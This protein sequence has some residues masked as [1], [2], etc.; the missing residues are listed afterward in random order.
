MWTLVPV[1]ETHFTPPFNQ[2]HGGILVRK[3]GLCIYFIDR[4]REN[5]LL[6]QCM[7]N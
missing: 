3:Q 1:V 6:R 4:K 5:M 2:S 7:L